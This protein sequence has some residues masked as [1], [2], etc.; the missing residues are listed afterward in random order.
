MANLRIGV[1]LA[2]CILGMLTAIAVNSALSLWQMSGINHRMAEVVNQQVRRARMITEFQDSFHNSTET[3]Y[4]AMLRKDWSPARATTLQ[5]IR[6][7]SKRIFAQLRDIPMDAQSAG[8]LDDV[9]RLIAHNREW[10]QTAIHLM[11]Q[12]LYP[13]AATYY[14]QLAAP[15]VARV[16]ADLNRI[17]TIQSGQIADAY[18][19]SRDAYAL[20][21]NTAI[22]TTV[23]F[24]LL[25]ALSGWWITGSITRPLRE[26]VSLAS[27][28][29]EGDFTVRVATVSRDET[30]QLLA[31]L[32]TMVT[33]LTSTLSAVRASAEHLYLAST[34][35]SSTSQSLSQGASEQDASVDQTSATLEQS[36]ASIAQNAANARTADSMARTVSEQATRGGSVVQQTLAAMQSIAER[37]SIIDDIAYQTNMLALNAAIEAAR[38]GEHGKGF[39]VVA[40]EVRKLAER[41]QVA[42]GE[43]GELASGS[44]AQAQAAG[45]LLEQ[46]VPAIA[47]TSEFVQEIS[48]ASGEQ[49]S[50]IAQLNQA[51]AQLST[52][53]QQNASASEQLAATAEE[54]NAQAQQLQQLIAQFKIDGQGVIPTAPAALSPK[55]LLA[56]TA[57]PL[58]PAAEAAGFVRF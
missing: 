12:G 25:A 1:R 42:A 53:T 49:A 44:V 54:M 35:V 30:G 36:S 24:A 20:A 45:D 46:I 19:A 4:E 51:M 48:A 57:A 14:S 55:A 8:L 3:L 32:S 50:G 37:I 5:S 23:L 39:A 38:A 58:A 6:A 33:R 28:V 34:Q 26:A 22:G 18:Q 47:K 29:A 16:R 21:R 41:S 31:A 11:T 9:R 10:Q 27:R 7:S 52:A 40:A 43:I 2:L 15:T 17:D 13:Q 56:A